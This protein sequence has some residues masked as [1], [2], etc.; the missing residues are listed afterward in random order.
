M[1]MWLMLSHQDFFDEG[2]EM[3]VL[4]NSE[5]FNEMKISNSS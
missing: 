2:C 1:L 3:P 4:L 5:H